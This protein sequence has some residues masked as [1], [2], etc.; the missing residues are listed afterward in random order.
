MSSIDGSSLKEFDA[1]DFTASLCSH[2][3][4]KVSRWLECYGYYSNICSGRRKK[5]NA[6][7]ADFIIQD[8]EYIKSCNKSWARLI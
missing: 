4:N 3:P 1:V 2:I 8:N 5:D 6:N 7:E